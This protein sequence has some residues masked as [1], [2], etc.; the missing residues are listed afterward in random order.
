MKSKVAITFDFN[1]L[2][3]GFQNNFYPKNGTF[4]ILINNL[5]SMTT[6]SVIDTMRFTSWSGVL[7]C[8]LTKIYQHDSVN[9]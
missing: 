7:N 4:V 3:D 2:G 6:A 1:H 8:C 9:S 5:A